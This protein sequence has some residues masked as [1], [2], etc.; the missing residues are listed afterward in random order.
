[1]SAPEPAVVEFHTGVA[2][3]LDLGSRLLRRA[4][5]SGV[6]VQCTA[7]PGLLS[8]LDETLWLQPERDFVPHVRLPVASR[9]AART[10]I[11]LALEAQ[12]GADAPTVLINAGADL[13]PDLLGWARIVEIV[14]DAPEALEAGRQRWRAYKAAGLMPRLAVAPASPPRI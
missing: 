9:L 13:A 10:P 2:D 1:M 12:S 14:A 6:R 3:L 4:Y 11:W 7:P 5:R 8:R